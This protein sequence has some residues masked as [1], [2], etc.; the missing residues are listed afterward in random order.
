MTQK[1][2]NVRRLYLEGIRDGHARAAV[3]AC[4]GD[5]YTQHSTGVR[6]GVE[7]FLEFFEPFLAR[8]PVREIEIVRAIEDGSYVFV[9]AFQSLNGGQAR[10][11]TTDLFDTDTDD[12]IVEHWDT[13]AAFVDDTVSGRTQI[14]GPTEITDLNKT[15]ANKSL[16]T[17]FVTEV[18][19]NGKGERTT[20]F[21]STETYHQHNP[22][23]GDGL[24]GLQVF[25]MALAEQGQ[26][27]VYRHI[28]TVIGQGNFVVTYSEVDL[29]GT[30]M[31][32]FDIFRVHEGKI[33]E[34]W[35]NMEPVPPRSEWANSGKF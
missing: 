17:E 32:V 5:R 33:V 27:M 1:L 31:A 18:L 21:V 8:N 16:V 30:E 2:D 26:A 29:A 34:H 6:D 9:H 7:G 10:W 12:K 11:V 4:T 25:M 28:H 20:D 24:E 14:D 22:Q 13:I 3:E 15:D 35:D 23:V 19:Q